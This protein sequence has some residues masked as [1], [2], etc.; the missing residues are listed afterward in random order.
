MEHPV[1]TANRR[2][3]DLPAKPEAGLAEWTSKIKAMQRQ[4]DADE[5]A[6]HKRLEEEIAASRLARLRRSTG[7]G[8][9][10]TLDL[11]TRSEYAHALNADDS[12]PQ[13]SA[14]AAVWTPSRQGNQDDALRK[15]M[16]ESRDAK[17]RFSVSLPPT[18]SAPISLAAFIG[19]R[20]TGPRLTRHAPQQDGSNPTQ[21]EQHRHITAPHPVFGRGGVAVPG[22]VGRGKMS[23]SPVGTTEESDRDKLSAVSNQT[24]NRD[25]RISTPSIVKAYAERAPG[26]AMVSQ[27]TIVSQPP[28]QRTISTPTGSPVVN[29]PPTRL[30]DVHKFAHPTSRSP[31]PRSTTP[32]EQRRSITHT[33]PPGSTSATMRSSSSV[34]SSPPAMVSPSSSPKP[35]ITVPSLV[36]PI[37]PTPR[38]SLG[39]QIPASANPSP[40]FLR[41]PPPKEPT[42]S[43]SKLQGR[44]F[45]QSMVKASTE[46]EKSSPCTPSTPMTERKDSGGKKSTPVLHRWQFTASGSVSSSLPNISPKPPP[47]HKACTV[48]PSSMPL[49]TSPPPPMTTKS[50]YTGKSVK[51]MASLPSMS[52]QET[53]RRSSAKAASDVGVN[54]SSRPRG[55]GSSSTMIAYVKPT[56]TSN[57]PAVTTSPPSVNRND[58]S[59][60]VDEL[61]MRVGKSNG[62]VR[63]EVGR[64]S[65]GLPPSSGKPLSHLTKDRAKKPRKVNAALA[66]DK[67]HTAAVISTRA[68]DALLSQS[69]QELPPA[70]Q[71]NRRADLAVHTQVPDVSEPIFSA[72]V[73]PSP[74][75]DKPALLLKPAIGRKP[76]PVL[77]PLASSLDTISDSQV[78]T[79]PSASPTSHSGVPTEVREKSPPSPRH[80]RI[81][82]T[83]N[84][85]T[86]M[87]VAQAFHELVHHESAMTETS[88]SVIPQASVQEHNQSRSPENDEELKSLA[89]SLG[90]RNG[91]ARP[92]IHAEK[93][94]SSYDRYSAIT[95]PPVE[96]EKT[97]VPSPANTMSRSAVQ[98]APERNQEK[99]DEQSSQNETGIVSVSPVGPPVPGLSYEMK[100]FATENKFIH[101][102]HAQDA[103][104][105]VDLD[106]LLNNWRMPSTE[107]G[108][109]QPISVDVMSVI[110][111]TATPIARDTYIFYDNDLLT[112]VYRAK[113]RSSGLV[114]TKVWAWRGKHCVVGEREERK[115]QELAR[116]YG[117]S[118]ITVHQ[119]CEPMDFVSVLGGKFVTRQGARTHW[120]AENT[121]MHVVRSIGE[122]I[123]IDELEFGI[124]NLCSGFS[125]CL[126][127]LDTFYVWYGFGS[128]ESERRA[129]LEYAQSLASQSS[130]LMEL[131]EG[132]SDNDEMFWMILGEG[133][134]AKADYWKWR[135]SAPAIY[136]RLWAVD[137]GNGSGAICAI[138]SFCYEVVVHD[139]VFIV[140]CVWELYV[141]V[142]SEA[143]GKRQDI[144][145]AL[146]TAQAMS[147]KIASSRPFAP[148]VHVIILPTQIPTD[149]RLNFRDLDEMELNCGIIPDHMNIITAK[150]AEEHLARTVWERTAVQDPA[151]LPLGV[152]SSNMS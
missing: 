93:R 64:Q 146:S 139:S 5:E 26:Q 49:H 144:R 91:C 128:V 125:Y 54:G 59:P 14:D 70:V 2:I 89:A 39:P 18:T 19:G 73:P 107:D 83:G 147:T 136:P 123:Y 108:D 140:D 8:Q 119:Y 52:T 104:P 24:S 25:R 92:A 13:Q 35:P 82:S 106:A 124:R 114:S 137:A 66:G 34:Q 111:N 7:Y 88:V 46:L 68:N 53:E 40:A 134:Y 109:L 84:R 6:E 48:D 151:M 12:T 122:A 110:G 3:L 105:S 32:H 11:S 45:V 31:A 27:G 15:L 71:T 74:L 126:S 30:A 69:A 51:S 10:S 101:I 76:P 94:K 80:T 61:G 22:M 67:P 38:L 97:P 55:L 148:T 117:T 65:G 150:E 96:E 75:K 85:A 43:I 113:V 72:L 143:R 78:S 116:R 79:R 20:A 112:V 57:Q 95:M 77:E 47:L 41:T 102:E 115:L 141:L 63:E 132:E 44:G 121:A 58:A 42:P 36:R 100:P 37:Q 98:P 60:G 87:D 99:P 86:V 1:N 29:T 62:R 9:A 23:A 90:Q 118:P 138:S 145:L 50:D 135:P 149:L 28:R 127:L 21:F 16:G 56:K 33:P 103:I 130:N 129:A 142:G 120:T 152:H 17:P 4:V 81:P 131:T 133:E